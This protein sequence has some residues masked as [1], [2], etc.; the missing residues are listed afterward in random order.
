MRLLR[1]LPMT[2]LVGCVIGLGVR[3]VSAKL[4]IEIDKSA[5][6]MTVSQDGQ[7]L[8]TWRV[9]TGTVAHD[10]PAGSFTPSRMEKDHFSREWD[11]APMPNS[12]FFTRQG[13]AVH[14][15]T[16]LSAIGRPASHGCVR[17][18]LKNAA[19]LFDLVK[20]E[21]MTNTRVELFGATPREVS[22]A[23]VRRALGYDHADS[24]RPEI[25][26]RRVVRQERLEDGRPIYW[27]RTLY[28]R[29]PVYWHRPTQFYLG[30]RWD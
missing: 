1:S 15:T 16:H 5:Q 28:A 18:E 26:T 11:D 23:I 30:S 6:L 27:G 9:S 12:I 14:G 7:R 19:V 29:P 4:L 22:P 3:P 20:Q 24:A 13:H 8:Y 10:T 25:F 21:G 2:L 17:L